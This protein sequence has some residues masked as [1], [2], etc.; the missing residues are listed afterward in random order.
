LQCQQVPP[1]GP[2]FHFSNFTIKLIFDY[3]TVRFSRIRIGDLEKSQPFGEEDSVPQGSSLGPLLFA[4][5]ID[6]LAKLLS[7]CPGIGFKFYADDLVNYA[8]HKSADSI[9]ID[10]LNSTLSVI[11]GWSLINLISITT[12]KTVAMFFQKSMNHLLKDPL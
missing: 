12:D 2:N 1:I 11:H 10:L 4:A 5:F 8:I 9:I 7:Q 3:L 6:D